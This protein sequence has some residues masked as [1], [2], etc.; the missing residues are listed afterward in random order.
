MP[1]AFN[2]LSTIYLNT[3]AINLDDIVMKKILTN[4]VEMKSII[5]WNITFHI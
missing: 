4:A 2:F 5:T 1:L 3:D